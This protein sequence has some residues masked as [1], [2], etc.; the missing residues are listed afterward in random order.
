MELKSGMD[1]EN[2]V[3]VDMHR[4]AR[5]H[6]AKITL[7]KFPTCGIFEVY[8]DF[9]SCTIMKVIIVLCKYGKAFFS[10]KTSIEGLSYI[11]I[12]PSFSF[13]LLMKSVPSFHLGPCHREK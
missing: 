1:G 8:M 10:S 7:Q 3:F 4:A 5:K 11:A 9:L 2:N 12:N 6:C 13:G